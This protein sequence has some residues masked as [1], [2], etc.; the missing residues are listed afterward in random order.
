M[1]AGLNQWYQTDNAYRGIMNILMLCGTVGVPGGGWCHYVGQEKIRPEAGW[2][3]FSFAQDWIP[4]S[5]QM[6]ATSYFYEH[7]DQWRYE[8]MP[9]V[10]YALPVWPMRSAIAAPI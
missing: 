7:A 2:A 8:R 1:G 10:L 4:A 5:R 3:E 6:N 9:L